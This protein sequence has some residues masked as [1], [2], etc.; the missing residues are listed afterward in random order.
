MSIVYAFL[1]VILVFV[2]N[3]VVMVKCCHQHYNYRSIYA[4]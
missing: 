3:V 1:W 4:L 2:A